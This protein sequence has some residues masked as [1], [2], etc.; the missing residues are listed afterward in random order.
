MLKKSFVIAAISLSICAANAEMQSF[1]GA[2]RQM[3]MQGAE[4]AAINNA[5]NELEA[6]KDAEMNIMDVIQEKPVVPAGS[7]KSTYSYEK[8]KMDASQFNGIGGTNIPSGVNQSKT[9]YRDDIGRLHC[10]GKGNI[11]KE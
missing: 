11:I 10:F 6:T 3:N 9:I 8:G 4:A 5:V 1:F 2:D 7:H